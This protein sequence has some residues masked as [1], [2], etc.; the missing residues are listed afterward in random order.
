MLKT[1]IFLSSIWTCVALA[2]IN[3]NINL[4]N[5]NPTAPTA[6]PAPALVNSWVCS[7][8]PFTDSFEALG[9]SKTDAKKKV[10]KLCKEKNNEMH[11]QNPQCDGEDNPEIGKWSCTTKAF[12]DT[13]DGEGQTRTEAKFYAM[14][15]CKAKNHEM[16]CQL[17]NCDKD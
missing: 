11:C 10:T 9:T 16:H 15:S 7:L 14:K 13:F 8:K 5:N 12:M 6:K 17:D 3:I 2:E 4:S 1:I